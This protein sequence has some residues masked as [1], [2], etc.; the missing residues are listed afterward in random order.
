LHNADGLADLQVREY[1]KTETKRNGGSYVK[2]AIKTHRERRKEEKRREK[3]KNKE[4][5]KN[6]N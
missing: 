2:R 3:G 4:G 5:R 6:S 1:Y